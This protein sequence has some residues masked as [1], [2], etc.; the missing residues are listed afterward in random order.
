M[1]HLCLV[2][3][4]ITQLWMSVSS[5]PSKVRMHETLLGH[6]ADN[7]TPSIKE[8]QYSMQLIKLQFWA[9]HMMGGRAGKSWRETV[10]TIIKRLSHVRRCTWWNQLVSLATSFHLGDSHLSY[11]HTWSSIE[12]GSTPS[13]RS[14]WGLCDQHSDTFSSANS[15]GRFGMMSMQVF[16]CYFWETQ[17]SR[18]NLMRTLQF[19]RMSSPRQSK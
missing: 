11:F 14:P 17:D 5:T 7:V 15:Q 4:R 18:E 10:Q 3:Q 16:A 6:R 8:R 19:S 2:M 9:K 13:A 12:N 1:F